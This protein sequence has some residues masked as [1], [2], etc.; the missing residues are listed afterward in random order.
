MNTGFEEFFST[1]SVLSGALGWHSSMH[2]PDHIQHGL[3]EVFRKRGKRQRMILEILD[4][5]YT[6]EGNLKQPKIIS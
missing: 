6:G 1:D 5:L 3:F 4:P 2:K